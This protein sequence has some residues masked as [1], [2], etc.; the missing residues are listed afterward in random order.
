MTARDVEADLVRVSRKVSNR[1]D[2][3][4]GVRRAMGDVYVLY[5]LVDDLLIWNGFRLIKKD[6][7]ISEE[8]EPNAAF[9]ARALKRKGNREPFVETWPTF[10]IE[11]VFA[12]L[13]RRKIFGTFFFEQFR[14]DE[15]FVGRIADWSSAKFSILAYDTFGEPQDEEEF[16]VDALTRI[17]FLDE[18]SKSFDLAAT[19]VNRLR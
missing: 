17:D 14:E 3:F 18:Y 1:E 10:D 11:S 2:D 19:K 8:P 7:M 12:L 5:E 15:E 9:Y 13:D 16:N 4:M 6:H